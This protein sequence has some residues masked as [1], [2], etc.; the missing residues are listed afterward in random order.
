MLVLYHRMRAISIDGIMREL[1]HP[2]KNASYIL[3]MTD[4]PGWMVIFM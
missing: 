2:F 4:R 1:L 3:V